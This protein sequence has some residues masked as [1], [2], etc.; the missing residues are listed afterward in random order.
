MML[1]DAIKFSLTGEV[2]RVHECLSEMS[3]RSC[4]KEDLVLL[5]FTGLKDKNGVE[6]YKGDIVKLKGRNCVVYW[7]DCGFALKREDDYHVW[8]WGGKLSGYC[9]GLWG[10]PPEVIGNI[11]E[12]KDLLK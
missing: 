7:N 11:Y 3:S 2:L 9:D 10:G 8:E 12:N 6:I 5:Q 1:V 4:N